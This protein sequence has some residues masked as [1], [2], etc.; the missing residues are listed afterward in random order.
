[1]TPK[2]HVAMREAAELTREHELTEAT[3]RIQSALMGSAGAA[4]TVEQPSEGTRLIAPPA[5]A[6]DDDA[7]DA[8]RETKARPR[9]PATVRRRLGD[10]LRLL[11][12]GELARQRPEGLRKAPRVPVP[13]G[14]AFHR[15]NFTGEAGSRDY[16]VYVPAQATAQKRPLLVMLHGCTQNPDDFA[17]GTAMNRLAEEQGFIVV[18]PRQS[19]AHNPSVC[20]NWFNP[21]DQARD[22]GEPSLIA[23]ITRAAIAEFDADDTRVF[24]AGLSAGGAMAAIMGALYPDLYAAVGIHSGLAYRAAADLPSALAA[25][26]GGLAKPLSKRRVSRG[27]KA[28]RTI[29]F[30]GAS[31]TTVAPSNADAIVADARAGLAGV[32]QEKRCDGVAG[33]R[34]FTRTVVSDARGVPHVERWAIE[35][36]GHAWSGGDPQGSY[37]DPNGPDASREMVRFFM[38]E[39]KG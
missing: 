28:I 32:V 6:R 5:P 8:G 19:T 30:H 29:V 3:L 22:A 15:R 4:E 34:A 7:T 38:E 1:M 35:G 26:R 33:G 12:Q 17:V 11:R 21:D 25:M 27:R 9:R 23:G 39:A 36:L 31:D 24:V 20:W 18:Y 16:A 10:V 14:A 2:F 13:E 37:A